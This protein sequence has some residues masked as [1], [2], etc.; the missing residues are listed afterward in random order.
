MIAAFTKNQNATDF[1][2]KYIQYN[3]LTLSLTL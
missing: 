2:S 3:S 1:I